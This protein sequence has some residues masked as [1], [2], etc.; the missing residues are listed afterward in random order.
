[1]FF[2]LGGGSGKCGL[3]WFWDFPSPFLIVC[4][5]FFYCLLLSIFVFGVSFSQFEDMGLICWQL[6]LSAFVLTYIST[7][8]LSLCEDLHSCQLHVY[9]FVCY[10]LQFLIR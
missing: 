5:L 8:L 1:M 4:F 6:L 10:H 2:F 3:E 9:V 7:D